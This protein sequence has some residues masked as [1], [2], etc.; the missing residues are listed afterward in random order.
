M[1]PEG[2]KE[3][4][5]GC[6]EDPRRAQTREIVLSASLKL[7]LE[8]GLDAV[9]VA[10]VHRSTGVA[11]TT[12][13]RQWPTRTDLVLATLDKLTLSKHPFDFTDDLEGDLRELLGRLKKRM[14][15]RRV[16][17][18]VSA[19]LSL[20][21][22]SDE[23]QP[24]ARRFLDGLLVKIR[25]RIAVAAQGAGLDDAT[26][27]RLYDRVVAPFLFRHVLMLGAIQKEQIDEIVDQT[28][29]ALKLEGFRIQDEGCANPP[30]P[31]KGK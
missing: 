23:H 19:T 22:E 1:T 2:K 15:K 6:R 8:E 4:P 29:G 27:E 20:A 25:D 13:Y 5:G 18:L 11:R 30:P 16:R 28:M 24:V 9:T 7:L 12:I 31:C 17:E 3:G 14:E 21:M 26:S 10:R